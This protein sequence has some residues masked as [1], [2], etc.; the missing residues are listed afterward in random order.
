MPRNRPAPPR[1]QVTTHD[2]RHFIL[3]APDW[4]GDLRIYLRAVGVTSSPPETI[5]TDVVSIEL[6]KRADAAAV[7]GLLDRWGQCA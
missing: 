3:V 2:R 7:Q 4:A 6:G 5:A 1:L